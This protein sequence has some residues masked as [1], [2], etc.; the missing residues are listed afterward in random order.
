MMIVYLPRGIPHIHLHMTLWDYIIEENKMLFQVLVF[1]TIYFP[2]YVIFR[3]ITVF[4]SETMKTQDD[5][6]CSKNSNEGSTWSIYSI[7]Q[8]QCRSYRADS[9]QTFLKVS[10]FQRCYC[11]LTIL[12]LL[13]FLFCVFLRKKNVF[14]FKIVLTSFFK[15]P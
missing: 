11:Y 12:I 1:A 2:L 5:S 15:Q 7:Q 9:Y 10:Y 6:E 13:Y 8:E 4:S 14:L 3:P